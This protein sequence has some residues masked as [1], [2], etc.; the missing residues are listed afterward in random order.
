M[1]IVFCIILLILD[2]ALLY[3]TRQKPETPA[4]V[5]L[6]FHSAMILAAVVIFRSDFEWKLFPLVWLFVSFAFFILGQQF[7]NYIKIGSSGY[8]SNYEETI[9]IERYHYRICV[10]II[11]IGVVNVVLQIRSYG[12]NISSFFDIDSLLDLN[13]TAAYERYYGNSAVSRIL[14]IL[15]LITQFG[16]LYGGY[17]HVYAEDKNEKVVCLLTI[18]PVI[19]NSLVTN[20]KSGLIGAVIMWGASYLISRKAMHPENPIISLR[21]LLELILIFVLFI[22]L[23]LFIMLLRIGRFDQ[24]AWQTVSEKFLIY[25]FGQVCAFDNWLG[26]LNS[27]DYG[28]GSNTFM[29]ITNWL[30]FTNRVQGVY[31]DV[32]RIGSRSTNVYTIFRGV[33]SDFGILG[34]WLF[35]FV[36]GAV[37]GHAWKKL[38]ICGQSGSL[39]EKIVLNA[40]YFMILYGMIVSPWVYTTY[41]LA[42]VLFAVGLTITFRVKFVLKRNS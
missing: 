33:I 36:L 29:A 13:A 16:I 38:H 18:F 1:T 14:L 4:G 24:S 32:V 28:F 34:G 7:G 31:S 26:E 40:M 5:N 11:L 39:S 42:Y 37:S 12:F 8:T 2:L 10:I 15:N 23:L 19:F 20:T 3:A 17:L 25:A 6:F 21:F 27:F 41:V 35:E 9:Q 30:G 22:A